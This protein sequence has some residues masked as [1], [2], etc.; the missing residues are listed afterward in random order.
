VKERES[1]G[2]RRVGA[3]GRVE[4]SPFIFLRAFSPSLKRLDCARAAL[5]PFICF[6]F[7]F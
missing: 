7:Y 6:L 1:G 2:G 5:L 3:G 4:G